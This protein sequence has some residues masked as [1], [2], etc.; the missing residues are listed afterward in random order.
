MIQNCSVK[1]RSKPCSQASCVVRSSC[2]TFFDLL[3][4]CVTIERI[5]RHAFE[6]NRIHE[7]IVKTLPDTRPSVPNSRMH[8]SSPNCRQTFHPSGLSLASRPVTLGLM[9]N[10]FANALKGYAPHE[11]RTLFNFLFTTRHC[12][13]VLNIRTCCANDRVK[14]YNQFLRTSNMRHKILL[15]LSIC[16][17]I[18]L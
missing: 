16:I 3:S 7:W 13:S 4:C 10:E 18:V 14:L 6:M 15:C 5:V 12:V 17:D 8:S 1:C 9:P 11:S 2:Q